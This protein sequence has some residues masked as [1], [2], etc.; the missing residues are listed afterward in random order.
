MANLYLNTYA[1]LVATASGRA[2]SETHG[3]LPFVDGSI[4]R[5]PDLQHPMPSISCLCRGSKFAPRLRPDDRV[6]YMTKKARYGH[7][8]RHWRMTAVLRVSRMFESHARAAAWYAENGLCVPSNCMVEGNP[9]NPLDHSHRQ[10]TNKHLPDTKFLQRWDAGY[11]F[12][13]KQNGT[14]VACEPLWVDLTWNAV[15]V[16]EEDLQHVFGKVPATRNPGAL[17]IMFLEPLLA[18]LRVEVVGASPLGTSS[19]RLAP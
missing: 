4:R 3:L 15:A 7:P 18:R 1:P 17:P 13:S 5:E 16:H 11:R 19:S 14:F 12:R 2:A 8:Q 9:P 6:I 10:N